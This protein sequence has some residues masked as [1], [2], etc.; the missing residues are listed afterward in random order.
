MRLTPSDQLRKLTYLTP[1]LLPLAVLVWLVQAHWINTPYYDQWDLVPLLQKSHNGGLGL[2][3]FWAQHNE[4]RLL[5]PQLIMVPLAWLTHWDTRY[6]MVVSLL[7]AAAAFAILYLIMRKTLTST[8]LLAAATLLTSVIFF[9]PIQYEN[10]LWGWQMQ[11]F[12]NI[13]GLVVA[14]WILN[15][16]GPQ[17]RLKHVLIA[18][19]AATFANY[20]LA[21]GMFVWLVCLPFF[22]VYR[23][24]RRWI[25]LWLGLAAVVIAVQWIGYVDPDRH[26]SKLIFLHD[27]VTFARY[28][29]AYVTNPLSMGSGHQNMIGVLYLLAV[30]AC[31]AYLVVRHRN[32]LTTTLLPWLCIGAYGALAAASTAVSRAGFGV[33]QANS[34]RY[35]T[36]SQLILV[37]FV[38]IAVKTIELGRT[39]RLPRYGAVATV[40]VI[41]VLV[42]L[43]YQHGVEMFDVYQTFMGN[44]RGC[45]HT[46]AT[47]EDSCLSAPL[48]WDGHTAWPL[49]E[50]IRSIHW[51]GL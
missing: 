24:L 17:A 37:A 38:V 6:E 18:A 3:D 40:A 1:A 36:L 2:G 30:L 43:S 48:Y 8:L 35:T 32:V 5:F 12:M 50:Y 9:S 4:H 15:R 34:S 20:S 41:A 16:G 31:L 47:A 51:G 19:A 42:G 10:W 29:L 7:F 11:W 21:N 46:A 14:V 25:P 27:P 28:L 39:S 49:L 22:V 23:P 33:E 13:A 26:P 44:V 45:A